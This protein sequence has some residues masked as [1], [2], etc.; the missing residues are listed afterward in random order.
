[1]HLK[2][3]AVH[4]SDESRILQPRIPVTRSPVFTPAHSSFCPPIENS[5]NMTTLP[6]SQIITGH[7]IIWLLLAI[8]PTLL[9]SSFAATNSI[10]AFS[11]LPPAVR[12]VSNTVKAKTKPKDLTP[13]DLNGTWTG[14]YFYDGTTAC[15]THEPGGA[16]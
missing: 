2:R 10:P 3:H 8:I 5:A 12:I 13:A 15:G 9:P 4:Q 16:I 7:R 14:G 11:A 6:K 1:M